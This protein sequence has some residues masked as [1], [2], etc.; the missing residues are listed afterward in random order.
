MNRKN[1]FSYTFF[2]IHPLTVI[3]EILHC[4]T[5]GTWLVQDRVRLLTDDSVL[6]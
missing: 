3:E 1:E 2:H 4:A 6:Y 5:K